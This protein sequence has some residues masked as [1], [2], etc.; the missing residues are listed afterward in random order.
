VVK[1]EL[2]VTEEE[3]CHHKQAFIHHSFGE[4]EC[5]RVH[6][7]I[8]RRDTEWLPMFECEPFW[9]LWECENQGTWEGEKYYCCFSSDDEG[10]YCQYGNSDY[11]ETCS[12]REL[13]MLEHWLQPDGTKP[14]TDFPDEDAYDFFIESL[15][16]YVYGKENAINVNGSGV[17]PDVYDSSEID[18]QDTH[19]V[20][21]FDIE[22]NCTTRLDFYM[23]GELLVDSLVLSVYDEPMYYYQLY[24]E[25]Y[26][27]LSM[28]VSMAEAWHGPW[29]TSPEE[30]W[31]E[32]IH[33]VAAWDIKPTLEQV[34]YLYSLGR[35][36]SPDVFLE[37]CETFFVEEGSLCVADTGD[38][39]ALQ[40][41]KTLF[42]VFMILC[43]VF[44]LFFGG[45]LILIIYKYYS[46]KEKYSQLPADEDQ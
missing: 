3:I 41:Y 31:Q 18:G 30:T 5:E 14:D 29:W 32:Q 12:P 46:K 21:V 4:P 2:V 39:S 25:M 37:S 23:N 1:G 7:M 15:G 19:L 35:D 28:V 45:L 24:W 34:Q 36:R 17:F 27:G 20:M 11:S 26:F 43:A 10:G 40:T 9:E 42:W 6:Y 44:V 22:D 8:L 16:V 38:D 13:V 33:L